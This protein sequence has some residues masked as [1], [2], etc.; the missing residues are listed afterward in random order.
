MIYVGTGGKHVFLMIVFLLIDLFSIGIMYGIYGKKQK[1]EN[2]MLLG[3]HLPQSEAESE[4]VL[5]FMKNYRKA[6]NR[7]YGWNLAAGM[8]VCGFC[9]WYLSIFMIFWSLWFIELFAGGFYVLCRWHRKLYDLKVERGWVGGG[10]SRIL[11]S[12]ESVREEGRRAGPSPHWH[13]FFCVLILLPCLIV[14]V[15]SAVALNETEA[16]LFWTALIVGFLFWGVHAAVRR[17]KDRVYSEDPAVNTEINRLQKAVWSWI[18]TGCGICNLSAYLLAAQS[19]SESGICSGPALIG[20]VILESLSVLFFL[21]GFPYMAFRKRKILSSDERP[22]YIDDDVYWKNG[23]YSNPND[24]KL[25]VQDWACPWNYT[26]NMARPA[27]RIC[28]AAGVLVALFSFGIAIWFTVKFEFTPIDM[29]LAEDGIKIT[30]GYSDVEIGYEEI[31]G[32]EVIPQLPEDDFR[33]VNGGEDPEKLV[34]KFRGEETGNCRMYI[35]IGYEPVLEIET[36][37][38]PVYINSRE[39]SQVEKWYLAITEKNHVLQSLPQ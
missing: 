12:A 21:V 26:T 32:L 31:T 19:V 3:V 36:G 14:Q 38:G 17:V 8:I 22:A 7:F 37:E 25:L 27:G 28:M 34:G 5:S 11:A 39:E 6:S 33:R 30:S 24:P 16:V 13:L 1:Y 20:Y 18:L 35:Y 4:E 10:G 23:W 2:G 15:R 29:E 9:F